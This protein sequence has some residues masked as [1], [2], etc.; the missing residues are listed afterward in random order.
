MDNLCDAESGACEAPRIG[1]G[2][3]ARQHRAN[4]LDVVYIGDPMC[5][6]CWGVSPVVSS[7]QEFCSDRGIGFSLVVGG[8]RPGGG[9]AWTGQFKA[10]LSDHWK[11]ISEKTGQTFGYKLFEQMQFEYDTEPACRAVVAARSLLPQTDNN[12]ALSR[13]FAS[14]QK[15]FYVDSFDPKEAS[16]YRDLCDAHGLHFDRFLKVF[17]DS[18]TKKETMGEFQIN[19]EWGVRAYPSFAVRTPN[20]VDVIA[21][22]FVRFPAIVERIEQAVAK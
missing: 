5:S 20:K 14:I 1:D 16:F 11:E 21:T 12:K 8:L 22:G 2:E 3:A 4:D 15:K 9:D 6:W 10:F 18:A 17:E 7:L 13:F 19:R